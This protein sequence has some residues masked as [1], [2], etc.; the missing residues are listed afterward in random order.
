MMGSAFYEI[1]EWVVA[2][3]VDPGLGIEFIGAQGDPW[4]SSKDMANALAGALTAVAILATVKAFRRG[5]TESRIE[6][7]TR[8]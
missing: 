1:T 8:V 5:A 3:H 6:H 2:V 7:L 4:D